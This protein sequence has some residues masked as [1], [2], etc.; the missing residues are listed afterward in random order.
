MYFPLGAEA[1]E[2]S[3][4]VLQ[5]LRQPLEQ[6]EL[7]INRVAGVARYP[8][9]FQLVLAAN[10]CP[11]GLAIGKGLDCSCSPMVRRR[12]F[13]RL[14]GPLLDRVDLQVEVNAVSRVELAEQTHPESSATIAQRVAAARSAQQ[15]RLAADGWLTNAEVPGSKLRELLGPD[16][17]LLSDVDRAMDRG[18]LS[19]RG[20]DRVLRVAWTLADLA[21][22]SCPKR[23]DIGQAL[24]LRTRGGA[25]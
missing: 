17:S 12:Y 2:F 7:V 4:R 25:Q 22:R 13:S 1:P 15:D 10:P 14:A 8:A 3:A 11:C 6:G 19:L 21:G 20:A 9:Q 23:R 18:V 5:T 16:R 24:L